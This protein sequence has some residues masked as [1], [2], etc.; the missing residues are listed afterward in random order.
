MEN[1]EKD[2]RCNYY[3]KAMLW[4]AFGPTALVLGITAAV[5][6]FKPELFGF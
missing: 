5:A 2:P 6:Y 1:C 3:S 4:F